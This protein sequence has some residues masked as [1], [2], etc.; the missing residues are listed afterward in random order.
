MIP[1]DL[2]P[3]I[4]R[5]VRLLNNWGFRTSDSGDGRSKL[6]T[7]GEACMLPVPNVVITSTRKDLLGEAD[8]LVHLLRARGG[9]NLDASRDDDGQEVPIVMIEASYDPIGGGAIIL[10]TGVDDAMMFPEGK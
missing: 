2:D 6:G 1:D 9:I 3:G 4:R 5:T 10:L 8:A 7:P